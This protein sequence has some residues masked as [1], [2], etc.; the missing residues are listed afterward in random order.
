ML[1]IVPP[2]TFLSPS[3]LQIVSV[4]EDNARVLLRLT[5]NKQVGLE[6]R[7]DMCLVGM[8]MAILHEQINPPHLPMCSV[9]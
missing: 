9:T 4:D 5:I 6:M 8:C 7:L 1:A 3:L 2:T